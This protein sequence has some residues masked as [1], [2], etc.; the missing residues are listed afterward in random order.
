MVLT[1]HEKFIDTKE[2]ECLFTQGEKF[3]DRIHFVLP[4]VNNDVD[5][6]GC[7]FAIRT[8]ASDGGMTETI[9]DVQHE[10]EQILLTWNVPE[11]VTAVPG[12]LQLELVGSKGSDIIIKYKMPAVYVKAAIMGDHLPP[13]DIIEEKLA[14]M[15]DILRQA[16]AKL[17]E[18]KDLAVNIS[19][20]IIDST[21]EIEGK[22]AD[23]KVT[24]ARLESLSGDITKTDNLVK[25]ILTNISGG[26]I[27][28]SILEVIAARTSPGLKGRVFDSL[29]DRLKEEFSEKVDFGAFWTNMDIISQQFIVD[30][31]EVRDARISPGLDNREFN[32][33]SER[34]ESE[35]SAANEKTNSLL[36]QMERTSEIASDAQYKANLLH[37]QVERTSEIASDAQYKAN[38]LH[39]QVDDIRD[40]IDGT[41]FLGNSNTATKLQTARQ[42]NGIAFDGSK[43]I[44]IPIK[45]CYAYDD[46]ST[47]ATAPWHKVA[48]CTLTKGSEDAYAVFHVYRTLAST[49]PGGILK[50]RI[51]TNPDVT[52][53]SGNLLWE[54]AN[55]INKEDFILSII[56]DQNSKTLT[57][58]LWVN[59]SVRWSGYQ[60]TMI[61]DTD[62]TSIRSDRWTLY[63][64]S[65]GQAAYTESYKTINSE[66][67]PIQ[68]PVELSDSGWTRM[69][70]SGG[71]GELYY[72][73]CGKTVELKGSASPN[74]D[75]EWTVCTL[76][77][78]YRPST[79]SVDVI[80]MGNSPRK[81]SIS[82]QGVVT[83]SNVTAHEAIR[84]QACF[85]VD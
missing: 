34:L 38:L 24:G 67:S 16:Q 72:R 1:A 17:D 82:T 33:L 36:S 12:M 63:N 68:N 55:N 75:N 29:S 61:A 44:T 77:D 14:Q 10:G 30:E 66:F 74:A 37:S 84:L 41:Q 78:G 20:E 28:Q 51:R 76:P 58:E 48:S 26:A 4:P 45:G 54:Y 27:G 60:F 53:Q 49:F 42:I 56:Q 5:I 46:S 62:R 7:A 59:I 22:A 52:L 11:T 31:K 79:A 6:S 71:N 32:S 18:A 15:N 23:A 70:I 80:V 81:L 2:I 69:T 35:F 43:D 65:V 8:V 13:P 25:G 50:V 73:K 9:L 47:I 21:L 85:L 83:V 64:S 39:S 57:A 3:S 19:A 40:N